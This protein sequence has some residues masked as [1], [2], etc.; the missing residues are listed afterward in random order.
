MQKEA[1][2][3]KKQLKNIHIEA[4]ADGVTVVLNGE[5]E[6]ISLTIRED[7]LREQIAGKV[8]DAMNRAMKKAQVVASEKMQGVMGA[9]GLPTDEGMRGL[10][11]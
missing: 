5:Q 3:I 9:M 1:K 4:E 11:Q 2:R 8:I 6:I 7:V 10:G